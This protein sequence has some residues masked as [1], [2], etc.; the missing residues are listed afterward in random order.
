[1]SPACPPP[2]LLPPMFFSSSMPKHGAVNS[3]NGC[4]KDQ[5][6]SWILDL[7]ADGLEE[8]RLEELRDWRK[9]LRTDGPT[10]CNKSFVLQK[11]RKD[12]QPWTRF[13]HQMWLLILGWIYLHII[14]CR[15]F[16]ESRIIITPRPILLP[17]KVIPVFPFIFTG[18]INQPWWVRRM[19]SGPQPLLK[20][21]NLLGTGGGW[22]VKGSLSSCRFNK[23]IFPYFF[24]ALFLP[25]AAN[26]SRLQILKVQWKEREFARVLHVCCRV[27]C[28][29]SDKS[30]WKP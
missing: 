22:A 11:E 17:I 7:K 26:D 28:C 5:S 24:P 1:M 25:P 6:T 29:A 27:A 23:F 13:G 15:C 3:K 30:I 20:P 19:D 12:S 18:F 14:L 4:F 2:P 8:Q 10:F 16:F 9:K 21:W